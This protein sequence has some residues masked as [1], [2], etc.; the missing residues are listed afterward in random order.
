MMHGQKNIKFCSDFL[1]YSHDT[2]CFL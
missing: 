2:L 1:T